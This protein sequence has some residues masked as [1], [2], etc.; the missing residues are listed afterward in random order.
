[1][2]L[3]LVG[4]VAWLNKDHV[5]DL[6]WHIFHIVF[7]C[8]LMETKACLRFDSVTM[9]RWWSRGLYACSNL[10]LA[11]YSSLVISPSLL[12]QI[13]CIFY[14]IWNKQVSECHIDQSV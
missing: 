13:F 14:L 7:F 10:R 6:F 11:S 1:M 4:I 8:W 12:L 9:P 5:R 3:I 2:G